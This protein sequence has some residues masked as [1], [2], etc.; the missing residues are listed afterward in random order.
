MAQMN[1]LKD[2]NRLI[3]RE[4]RRGGTDWE[5]GISKCK[6]FHVEWINDESLL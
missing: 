2:R 4:T 1:Y 3:N 6:L 5:F